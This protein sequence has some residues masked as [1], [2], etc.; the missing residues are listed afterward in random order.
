M[1]TKM[2]HRNADN[3]GFFDYHIAL[4]PKGTNALK[5]EKMKKMLLDVIQTELTPQQRFCVVGH[6][7]Y[8]M[9]Q[10]DIASELGISCSTVSRHIA[11]GKR[12]LKLAA[13]HFE[14]AA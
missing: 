7:M 2:I 5:L 14:S 1:K 9:K 4:Q 12:K 11:A 8:G 3:E 6:L 10:K 13:K